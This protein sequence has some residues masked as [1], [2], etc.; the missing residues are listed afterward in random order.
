MTQSGE[1]LKVSRRQIRRRAPGESRWIFRICFFDLFSK[2]LNPRKVKG[3][4][5]AEGEAICKRIIYTFSSERGEGA[6]L[7]RFEVRVC[8]WCRSLWIEMQVN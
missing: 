3:T 5:F 6:E 2:I 8:A 1:N 4:E 7:E